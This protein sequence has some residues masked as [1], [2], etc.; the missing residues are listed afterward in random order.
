M[1]FRVTGG[2]DGQSGISVGTRRYEPGDT[3]ELTQ[4]KAQWLIDRGLLEQEGRQT[5]TP[6]PEEI[7]TDDDLV[8]EPA[9]E[10]DLDIAD[11]ESEDD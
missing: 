3:I 2:A 5:S 1:K 9:D 4:A 6:E 8:D 7:E 11:D 10:P